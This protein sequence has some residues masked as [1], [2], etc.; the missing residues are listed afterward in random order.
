NLALF[1]VIAKDPVVNLSIEPM[2]IEGDAC[3]A[4]AAFF[5]SLPKAD[6]HVCFAGT[7]G[8][9]Q[10][11]QKSARVRLIVAVVTTSPGTDENRPLG[12]TGDLASL[13][14]V[15]GKNRRAEAL[16]QCDT[17]SATRTR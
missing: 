2:L 5:K 12:S 6:V 7:F 14:N 8:V 11:Y 13:S 16:W 1:Q 10:R 9:L 3:T 15:V 17:A 4:V